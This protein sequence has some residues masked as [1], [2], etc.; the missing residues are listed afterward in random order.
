MENLQEFLDAAR[1]DEIDVL[2]KMVSEG[3]N[4]DSQDEYGTTAL[5]NA[6]SNGNLDCVKLLVES[7][8]HLL[9][10]DAGNTALH[11]AVLLQQQDVV[12]YLLASIPDIDVLDKNSF[13]QSAVD[14]AF[15]TGNEELI[16]TVLSHDSAKKLEESVGYHGEEA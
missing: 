8:C 10:N 16:D 14:V 7:G 15:N 4:V 6:C 9:K 3:F 12:K 2:K 11:R 1:Y 13:G 5:H